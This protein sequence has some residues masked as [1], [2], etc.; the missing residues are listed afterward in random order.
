MNLQLP[1]FKAQ[2]QLA[3]FCRT[4]NYTP[5][6]GV[7]E[8]HI[9]Q[10][11]KL[12]FNVVEDSLR[13]AYPLTYNLL[14]EEEWD[15]LINIFFGSHHCQ[16]PQIWQMPGELLHF[17]ENTNNPLL[18]KYPHLKDLIL[19]E[20]LEIDVYMMED[21]E[22]QPYLTLKKDKSNNLVL[23][24]EL[25]IL[26]LN[27]PV[28]LKN[29]KE[30]TEADRGQYFV[31]LHREPESG[32][33]EFSNLQYP[34]VELLELMGNGSTNFQSLLEIFLKYIDEYQ[35]TEELNKF[36]KASLDSRLIL[37]FEHSSSSN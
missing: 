1:T 19:F 34:H 10:Y 13:S 23:N 27:Y 31:S 6:P 22:S 36:I 16:S 2:S 32:N 20:W 3:E 9:Y 14:K 33:V 5:I 7:N 37:G 28:H 15:N 30:I 21:I 35:A 24:P 26:M 12:I 8:K 25:K 4:G 29:A 18:I 11:R 17:L